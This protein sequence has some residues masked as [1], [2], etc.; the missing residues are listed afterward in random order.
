MPDASIGSSA[1]SSFQ[2]GQI[3]TAARISIRAIQPRLAHHCRI[4]NTALISEMLSSS[5]ALAGASKKRQL[6]TASSSNADLDH[7]KQQLEE[8]LARQVRIEEAL[9]S[10]DSASTTKNRPWCKAIKQALTDFA[11]EHADDAAFTTVTREQFATAFVNSAMHLAHVNG[12]LVASAQPQMSSGDSKRPEYFSYVLNVLNTQLFWPNAKAKKQ[13]P[14]AVARHF[15]ASS[16]TTE[17]LCEV[18]L[19]TSRRM[20][21]ASYGNDMD[22][23]AQLFE[24]FP[25]ETLEAETFASNPFY[26]FYRFFVDGT[27]K[28]FGV[29]LSEATGVS[30]NEGSK[31]AVACELFE[32]AIAKD[33][34]MGA[35]CARFL[36]AEA[37]SEI[38][39][40]FLLRK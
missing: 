29:A 39:S 32:N 17:A 21:I 7:I 34:S 40:S 11:K 27:E 24:V 16:E 12:Q 18:M 13:L 25:R 23:M 14:P 30:L 19:T 10:S 35:E 22:R 36:L 2:L 38:N 31:Q 5:F 15:A 1:V 8:V 33:P 26:A 4:D 6:P 3:K 28:R 9:C 37:D 20:L